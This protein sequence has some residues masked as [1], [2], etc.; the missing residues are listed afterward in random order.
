MKNVK[1]LVFVGLGCASLLLTGCGS[2]KSHIMTCTL[3]SDGGIREFIFEYDEDD[4]K[5]IGANMSMSII[6]PDDV[7]DEEIEKIKASFEKSC[8]DEENLFKN[9]SI[10]VKDNVIEAT[11]TLTAE[12][13]KDE[14]FSLSKEETKSALEEGNYICK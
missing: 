11:G 5:V 10:S 8:S 14:M 12:G 7:F 9:C 3:S 6:L 2:E 13:L 4:E 1:Y